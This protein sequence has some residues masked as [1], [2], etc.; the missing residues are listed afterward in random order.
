[1]A[2]MLSA[3]SGVPLA[4]SAT[5]REF[6]ATLEGAGLHHAAISMLTRLFE[7]VRY[8]GRSDD[9]RREDALAALAALEEEYGAP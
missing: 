3:R 5:P 8:G 1:M 2:R 9:P 7:E 6:R 4:P